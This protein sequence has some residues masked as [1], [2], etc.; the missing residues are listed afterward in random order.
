MHCYLEIVSTFA[1]KEIYVASPLG[2][3]PYGREFLRNT[4]LPLLRANHLHPLDPWHILGT[5]VAERNTRPPGGAAEAGARVI[6]EQNEAMLRSCKGVLAILDG[7]DVDSGVAAEI[8]FAAALGTP[9]VGY[10]GD[11]RRAGEPLANLVNLQVEHFIILS[12][13]M[14]T[15]SLG[16]AVSALVALTGR[17]IGNRARP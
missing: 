1:K 10:R 13:G 6:G 8:G 17:S 5:P 14:I 12:G 16:D 11:L 9:I 4:V 7:A 15:K 3:V 2:F